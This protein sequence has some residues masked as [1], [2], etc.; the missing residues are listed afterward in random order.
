MDYTKIIEAAILLI[1]ALVTTYVI[2]WLKSRYTHQQLETWMYWVKIAVAAAE[3]IYTA[4]QGST[5]KQYVVAYLKERGIKYNESTINNM[6]EA[7]VLELHAALKKEDK[8]DAEVCEEIPEE[9]IP[10]QNEDP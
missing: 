10:P 4:A 1:A 3:Q 7:A 5:K 2:P 8:K 9:E 6:I